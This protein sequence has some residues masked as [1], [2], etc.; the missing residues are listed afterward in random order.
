LEQPGSFWV[1]GCCLPLWSPL[2]VS[3]HDLPMWSPDV[4]SR[5][6]LPLWSP[7]G[8]L[9]VFELWAVDLFAFL[10]ESFVV[11]LRLAAVWAWG[12]ARCLGMAS[13]R[14]SGSA[15]VPWSIYWDGRLMSS[16]RGLGALVYY[17]HML[18]SALLCFA[19]LCVALLGLC[20]LLC[21][22]LPC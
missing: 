10:M 17:A 3:H 4:A 11:P 14:T 1:A 16:W 12:P 7:V 18:C 22:F 5:C 6:G 13:L 8:R 2:V 20:L 15:W 19:L 9:M 21:L